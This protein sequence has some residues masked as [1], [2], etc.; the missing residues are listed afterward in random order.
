MA[1]KT[2]GRN[3][4][5]AK[6]YAKSY[7]SRD[8]GG[9]GSG[10]FRWRELDDNVKF[11]QPTA[12]RGR[13]NIIPYVI[14][15][16]NHPLVKKGEFEIGD[17]DYLMDIWTHRM[18]GPSDSTVLC[19]KKT[20][21]KPCPICEQ[22]ESLKKNGKEKEAGELKP[23]RRCFYNVEDLKNNPGEVM[24]FEVSHFLFEKELID[25]ARGDDS[26]EGFI[27]FADPDDGKEIKY[28]CQKIQR[29]GFEFNEYK[30]FSFEDRDEPLSE[31]LLEKAISFDAIMTIPTYEEAQAILY[32]ADED[33][34]DADDDEK[35]SKKK[36]ATPEKKKPS[37]PADDDEEDE[38]DPDMGDD[39]EDEDDEEDPPPKKKK[40]E[41]SKKKPSRDEDDEDE[42]EDDEPPKKKKPAKDED[43]EDDE[44]PAKSKKSEKEKGSD[45]PVGKCPFGHRFG[46]DCDQHDDCDDC[47]KWDTCVNASGK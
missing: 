45:K 21:G 29:G 31:D 14:K 19:L 40:P 13:I 10:V 16:K 8:Q 20:F 7:E 18:V 37:K 9:G 1:K 33:D 3:K 15:T 44:P 23:S 32:G 47:D 35:P 27:A 2:K 46:K 11:F 17:L 38:E 26:D 12:G 36:P 34:D 24:V 25:E 41:S 22:A 28:R 4:S 42:D 30:S 39:E 5:L 6:R 43:D